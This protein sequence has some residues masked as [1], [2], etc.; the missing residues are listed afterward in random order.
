[1]Q[2]TTY[3]VITGAIAY[4][5]SLM[6]RLTFDGTQ[7]AAAVFVLLMYGFGVWG[8]VICF[9][10]D[11]CVNL[12]LPD[13][14]FSVFTVI[15]LLLHKWTTSAA[16]FH[17]PR[18]FFSVCFTNWTM[19]VALHLYSNSL[20]QIVPIIFELDAMILG[21]SHRA[22]RYGG[23][24][25]PHKS[26]SIRH[27]H[28]RTLLAKGFFHFTW[29]QY[30]SVRASIQAII[31]PLCGRSF[32]TEENLSLLY[33]IDSG[34]Y[35]PG[36]DINI[37]T[38]IIKEIDT[39]DNTLFVHF[40]PRVPADEVTILQVGEQPTRHH[41]FR[42]SSLINIVDLPSDLIGLLFVGIWKSNGEYVAI[43]QGDR[44]LHFI[45][46]SNRPHCI[47]VLTTSNWI[48]HAFQLG[49]L[50]VLFSH[51]NH[52][53]FILRR[54]SPRVETLILCREMVNESLHDN[55]HFSE[56]AVGLHLLQHTRNV[57][58]RTGLWYQVTQV[59]VDEVR[60]SRHQKNIKENESDG[61]MTT[62]SFSNTYLLNHN[63]STF[64]GA[65]LQGLTRTQIANA[66]CL[67]LGLRKRIDHADRSISSIIAEYCTFT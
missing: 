28:I 10:D 26:V 34:E 56:P 53:I 1:M 52:R 18:W 42:I 67:A 36:R 40:T 57:Y 19:F 62:T 61:E 3:A 11:E 59:G 51:D 37:P 2:N 39:C 12:A 65:I 41:A 38:H 27:H 30:W 45:S 13:A 6:I 9:N 15:V 8:C 20:N 54:Q 50:F 22:E 23:L 63:P 25:Y 47:G 48:Q 64:R 66:L 43:V 16:F 4:F 55:I 7:P 33:D 58:T 35:I 49:P 44:A 32:I 5:C 21:F 31:T 29:I 17:H 24:L 46:L 14:F 60:L